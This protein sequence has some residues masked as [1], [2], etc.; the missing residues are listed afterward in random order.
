MSLFDMSLNSQHAAHLKPLGEMTCL[1]TLAD[2]SFATRRSG[3]RSGWGDARHEEKG[4]DH[5]LVSVESHWQMLAD[6]NR[7]CAGLLD[8]WLLQ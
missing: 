3:W 5:M 1:R 2:G 6:G 7:P 4:H 8:A